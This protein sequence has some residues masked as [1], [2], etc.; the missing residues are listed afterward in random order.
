MYIRTQ[1]IAVFDSSIDEA[2]DFVTNMERFPTFFNGFGP[3]SGVEKIELQ[4]TEPSV[5]GR[6]LVHSADGS[7]ITE[8]IEVFEPNREHTYRLIDGFTPPFVWMVSSAQGQ[9][10]LEQTPKGTRITWNYAFTIR[11]VLLSW[12]TAFIV[13]VFFRGAMQRCLDAMAQDINS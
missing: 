7:C 2:W 8:E 11:A 3:I 1:A 5:G 4:Y 12:L 10:L 13:K 6:R 9:W